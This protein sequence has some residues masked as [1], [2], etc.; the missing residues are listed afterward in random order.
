MASTADSEDK[1]KR[2]V[3]SILQELTVGALDLFDPHR[4]MGQFLERVAERMGCLA[5]LVLAEPRPGELRLVDA[6]GLAASS[7]PLPIPPQDAVAPA[8]RLPYPELADRPVV[9]WRFALGRQAESGAASLVLCFDREPPSSPQYHGMMRRLASTFQTAL[10]HRLLYA[11][12]I[13]SEQS[14]QRAIR[15]REELIAVV[16][17]DLKTPLATISMT[18]GLLIDELPATDATLPTR[19]ALERIQRSSNRMSRLIRDLLDL[20][21]LDEGHLSINPRPHDVNSLILDSVEI[22]RQQATAKALRLEL[23]VNPGAERVLCDRERILQVL[24]NL[25]SN[26]VKFTPLGGEIS[27]RADRAGPE[28][29]FAVRDTG[30]GVP[31]DQRAR[32][33]DRYWQAEET[34]G[35]GTGL[36]LSIAKGLVEVHGGRIW[37]TS[38]LGAGSTFLFTL[39]AAA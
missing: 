23:K 7:R 21:K 34:A 38:Q 28:V 10:V 29:V 30:P 24:G 39:P 17:H 27:V 12:T 1:D 6:A 3:L 19:K 4:P 36:G 15:A 31:E 18:T 32:I 13:E 35:T 14:A 26:A 9:Q 37:V 22:L 20:A 11:R 16:S 25:V 33:F 8:L 2:L 5:V